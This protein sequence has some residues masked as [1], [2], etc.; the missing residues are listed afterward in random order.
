MIG[1]LII[2]QEMFKDLMMIMMMKELS[3]FS[4]HKDDSISEQ[5]EKNL[6]L[7]CK[8]QTKHQEGI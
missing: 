3:K 6:Y 1:C 2:F 4:A 5:S 8:H 7:I